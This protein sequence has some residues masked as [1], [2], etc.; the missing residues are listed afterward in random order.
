M[1]PFYALGWLPGNS[2]T[3]T[4]SLFLKP[5]S[6]K[7]LCLNEQVLAHSEGGFMVDSRCRSLTASWIREKAKSDPSIPRCSF[8]ERLEQQVIA[9]Y[10]CFLVIP[11]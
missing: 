11:Y 2:C 7:H 3:R 1:D 6:R 5:V 4:R 10:C 8:Y 9:N